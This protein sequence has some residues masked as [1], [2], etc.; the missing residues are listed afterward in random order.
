VVT[1]NELSVSKIVFGHTAV[2][3]QLDRKVVAWMEKVNDNEY[4]K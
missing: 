3:E 2:Q 1:N 4:R